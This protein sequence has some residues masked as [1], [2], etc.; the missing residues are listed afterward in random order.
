M[1]WLLVC[2]DSNDK[3]NSARA[4]SPVRP[5]LALKLDEVEL[6]RLPEGYRCLV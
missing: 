1:A 3:A 4:L 5:G 2:L 6:A